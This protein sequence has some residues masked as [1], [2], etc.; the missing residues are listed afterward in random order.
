MFLD[1]VVYN[2]CCT[3]L[4]AINGQEHHVVMVWAG[5]LESEKMYQ[6]ICSLKSTII[7][8]HWI[9]SWNLMVESELCQVFR[10]CCYERVHF[11]LRSQQISQVSLSFTQ[12]S[13]S[14]AVV[15]KANGCSLGLYRVRGASAKKYAGDTLSM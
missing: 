7:S 13:N 2:E 8:I 11:N 1:S 10:N 4:E 5:I 3:T 12:H 14:A 6:T 9:N 15:R